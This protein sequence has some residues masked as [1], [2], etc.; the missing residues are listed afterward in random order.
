MSSLMAKL[1]AI[2]TILPK[3][4]SGKASLLCIVLPLNCN[5]RLNWCFS[6]SSQ[7]LAMAMNGVIN[8]HFLTILTNSLE[9]TIEFGKK[10]RILPKS[11]IC[12]NCKRLLEK[13]YFLNRSVM[14]R[15]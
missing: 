4:H 6:F 7:R 5:D 14:Q 1:S 2:L 3:G 8:L 15:N 12:P 9:E 10:L 11:V 13:P